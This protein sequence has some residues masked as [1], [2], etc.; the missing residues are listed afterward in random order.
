MFKAISLWADRKMG[1]PQGWGLLM[2][3]ATVAVLAHLVAS[4]L[5]LLARLGWLQRFV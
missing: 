2:L 3:V 4:V 5:L 1:L